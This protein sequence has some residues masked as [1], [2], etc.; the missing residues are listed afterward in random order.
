MN[1]PLETVKGELEAFGAAHDAATT[2]RSRRMLNITRET[3]E[4][5]LVLARATAA[6]RIL[7]I[8]TS[9]EDLHLLASRRRPT[10]SP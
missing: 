9:N 8:G 1:V 2:D 7:E 6:R 10:G 4:F 5:L 3:G